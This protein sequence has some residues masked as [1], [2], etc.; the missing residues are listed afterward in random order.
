VGVGVKVQH[1]TA[2]V[3][4]TDWLSLSGERTETYDDG[5]AAILGGADNDDGLWMSPFED[6]S[7]E[8]EGKATRRFL[9]WRSP[10]NLGEYVVLEPTPNSHVPLWHGVEVWQ[11]RDST[12]LPV[13]A[14]KQE[15]QYLDMVDHERVGNMEQAEVYSPETMLGVQETLKK[16]Q[17]GLELYCNTL[18][19][20]VAM[21]GGVPA[22]APARLEDVVDSKKTG[23]DVSG[24]KQWCYEDTNVALARGDRVPRRLLGRLARERGRDELALDPPPVLTGERDGHW[25]D[26]F[27]RAWKGHVQQVEQVRDR[28][29]AEA[30][31][32]DTLFASIADDPES[33]AAGAR[34]NQMYAVTVKRLQKK[35]FGGRQKDLSE[36]VGQEVGEDCEV[37]QE[38]VAVAAD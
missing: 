7:P 27:D 3:N 6:V 11:K 30:R 34:F 29:M 15:V 31:P 22:V 1:A 26:R 16:N 19:R 9:V 20:H 14:D 32:P 36:R 38:R 18:L 28:L 33:L 2:W 23:A 12:L 5:I 8:G 4:D 35:G 24:V 17:G 37:R 10:N 21:Y 13:H 25:L